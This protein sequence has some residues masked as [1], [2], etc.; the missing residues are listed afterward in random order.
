[1]R[2]IK[3]QMQVSIDGYVAGI[4]GEMKEKENTTVNFLLLFKQNL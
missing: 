4:N 3:L 2:K 1:M